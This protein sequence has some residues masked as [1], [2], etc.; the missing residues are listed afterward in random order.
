MVR[1]PKLLLV[2]LLVLGG[3]L[4]LGLIF[5]ASDRAIAA[6]VVEKRCPA[7]GPGEVV[8]ETRLFGIRHT[9][10]VS[11][12]QCAV[13]PLNAYALYHLRSGHTIIYES[14]GGRCIWDSKIG[15]ACR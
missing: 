6:D 3:L 10:P 14:E 5:Y 11:A 15:A 13:V 12:T 9:T 1:P 8:S 7:F 2:L 4:A